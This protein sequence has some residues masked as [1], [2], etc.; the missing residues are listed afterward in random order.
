MHPPSLIRVF[1]VRMKKAWILIERTAKTLIRLSLRW[2]HTHFVG[3]VMSWLILYFFHLQRCCSEKQENQEVK[4]KYEKKEAYE[5][6][7][8]RHAFVVC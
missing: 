8:D 3:F 5:R 2:A 1:A 6:S 7:C 4:R